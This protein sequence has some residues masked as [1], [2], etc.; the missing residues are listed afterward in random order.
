MRKLITLFLI[1]LLSVWLGLKMMQDPGYALFL[2]KDWTIE[3]PLWL[4][5]FSILLVFFVLYFLVRLISGTRSLGGRLALWSH[6]RKNKAAGSKTIQ[7]LIDLSKGNWAVA[8]KKLIRAAKNSESPLINYLAAARAAQES[9]ASQRRDKYLFQAKKSTPED[10]I[11]VELS[12]AQL[13]INHGQL[14]QALA[15]LKHLQSLMPKHPYILKLLSNV[16]MDLRDWNGLIRLLPHLKKYSVL[17]SDKL[18]QIEFD[19]YKGL[20][21]KAADNNDLSKLQ[22]AWNKMPKTIKQDL[23]VVKIYAACLLQQNSAHEL[24]PILKEALRKTWDRQLIKLYG[25]AVGKDPKKQLSNAESWLKDQ[26]NNADLLLTLGRLSMQNQ[27][28]GKARNY[29]E[30]SLKLE[31]RPETY[32]E[33]AQVMENLNEPSK[34]SEYYRKGLMALVTLKKALPAL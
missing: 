13:Q 30:D 6:R 32:A 15:S 19:A 4:S 11:A 27:L 1:L 18:K 7:G 23:T 24:E 2:W 14:E 9:G 21:K 22:A 31:S 26:P 17:E 28:W 33:L 12:Q 16:Y 5:V 8:E 25:I 29:L 3:M 20:M 34:A 10:K